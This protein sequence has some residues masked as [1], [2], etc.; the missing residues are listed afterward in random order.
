MSDEQTT[1]MKAILDKMADRIKRLESQLIAVT[2]QV[3]DLDA[4]LTA[5]CNDLGAHH[6]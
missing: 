3:H 6:E 5:H 4:D 1:E 2:R